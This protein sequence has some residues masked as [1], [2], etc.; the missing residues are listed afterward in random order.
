M[1]SPRT[2]KRRLA[3][4]WIISAADKLQSAREHYGLLIQ[5]TFSTY[6]N[7]HLWENDQSFIPKSVNESDADDVKTLK[8]DLFILWHA[9]TALR[10]SNNKLRLANE[11]IGLCHYLSQMKAV[12]ERARF[13]LEQLEAIVKIIKDK[14]FSIAS[15]KKNIYAILKSVKSYATDR[16]NAAITSPKKIN[17]AITYSL[18]APPAADKWWYAD[19]NASALSKK[20]K[21]N[22]EASILIDPVRKLMTGLELIFPELKFSETPFIR[23]E[24]VLGSRGGYLKA[25]NYDDPQSLENFR[26]QQTLQQSVIAIY[27]SAW[28][29]NRVVRN[30]STKSMVGAVAETPVTAFV[31]Q[32]LNDLWSIDFS[33]NIPYE[34]MER[35]TN[36]FKEF[37]KELK[38]NFLSF[39]ADKLASLQDYE[40]Q[41]H[42]RPGSITEL[43]HSAFEKV[44]DFYLAYGLHFENPFTPQRN[45]VSLQSLLDAPEEKRGETQ[46]TA[47]KKLFE[48]VEQDLAKYADRALPLDAKEREDFIIDLIERIEHLLDKKLVTDPIQKVNLEK[49]QE[50]L[51]AEL[52]SESIL[53]LHTYL[54]ESQ[55][56]NERA[57]ATKF[58]RAYT[59]SQS[60][61]VSSESSTAARWLAAA[62]TAVGA[63]TP[64]VVKT[65]VG[66]FFAPATAPTAIVGS[67]GHIHIRHDIRLTYN[68]PANHSLRDVYLVTQEPAKFIYIDANGNTKI[69]LHNED[70][71][72]QH[73]PFLLPFLD[74]GTEIVNELPAVIAIEEKSAADTHQAAAPTQPVESES[75][76]H[77]LTKPQLLQLNK[78]IT[79][80]NGP[81]EA[82]IL[83]PNLLE[84]LK[85]KQ[86]ECVAQLNVLERRNAELQDAIQQEEFNQQRDKYRSTIRLLAPRDLLT[87]IAAV[88]ASKDHPKLNLAYKNRLAALAADMDGRPRE[89]YL[90]I[91]HDKAVELITQ[92]HLLVSII[93]RLFNNPYSTEDDKLLC[94]ELMTELWLTDASMYVDNNV[95]EY[96]SEN[97]QQ[98]KLARHNCLSALLSQL[99]TVDLINML[100]R[101]NATTQLAA[102]FLILKNKTITKN[103]IFNEASNLT[104]AQSEE[105]G[106]LP[107]RQ[108]ILATLDHLYANT[109][110]PE[111][112]LLIG[113]FLANLAL[114]DITFA[115][116]VF[117]GELKSLA[118][119]VKKSC[120]E[121][122]P[123]FT[124][125][126]YEAWINSLNIQ[127]T[128]KLDDSI[129]RNQDIYRKMH[130]ALY[131]YASKENR[132]KTIGNPWELYKLQVDFMR[133]FITPNS[134]AEKEFILL[135]ANTAF[136]EGKKGHVIRQE[137]ASQF[138]KSNGASDASYYKYIAV[139]PENYSKFWN[140]QRINLKNEIA[141]QSR[142]IGEQQKL[143][144][145]SLISLQNKLKNARQKNSELN[146]ELTVLE[147]SF[148]K[149]ET[150]LK[151]LAEISA[152]LHATNKKMDRKCFEVHL[153]M[154][155]TLEQTASLSTI[156]FADIQ[157]LET[158]NPLT[159]QQ[160]RKATAKPPLENKSSGDGGSDTLSDSGDISE[161]QSNSTTFTLDE[162]APAPQPSE[163]QANNERI[164]AGNEAI[165]DQHAPQ[166]QMAAEISS[167]QSS[168]ASIKRKKIDKNRWR[169]SAANAIKST[170]ENLG[171]RVKQLFSDYTNQ[172]LWLDAALLVAQ[173]V[174]P[175]DPQDIKDL[176][177]SFLI[178][179]YAEDALRPNASMATIMLNLKNIVTA[180]TQMTSASKKVRSAIE[181]LISIINLSK[182]SKLTIENIHHRFLQTL[183]SVKTMVA[184]RINATLNPLLAKPTNT[185][186]TY[187]QPSSSQNQWWSKEY[188][189]SELNEF[190]KLNLEYSFLLDPVRKLMSGLEFIFPELQFSQAVFTN[191]GYYEIK[192][193]NHEETI[194]NFREQQTLKQSMMAIYNIMWSINRVSRSFTTHTFASATVDSGDF[195]K[196]AL[197]NLWLIDFSTNI[198]EEINRRFKEKFIVYLE[199]LRDGLLRFDPVNIARIRQYELNHHLKP[200]AI[201]E[202]L[203]LLFSRVEDFYLAYNI[204]FENPFSPRALARTNVAEE[205]KKLT[206]TEELSIIQ[207]LSDLDKLKKQYDSLAN[208]LNQFANGS[209]EEDK[210]TF[211]KQ[212]LLDLTSLSKSKH[213]NPEQLSITAAEII[214]ISKLNT[215]EV[216]RLRSEIKPESESDDDAL[217]QLITRL[218]NRPILETTF[219]PITGERVTFDLQVVF[220]LPDIYNSGRFKNIVMLVQEPARLLMF[221][222][223][224]KKHLIF[225]DENEIVTYAKFLA[226]FL[227]K[228]T[229]RLEET[230]ELITESLQSVNIPAPTSI[231]TDLTKE[232]LEKLDSSIQQK[233]QAAYVL[234]GVTGIIPYL[235]QKESECVEQIANLERAKIEV[236]DAK[237]V[238]SAQVDLA[239]EKILQIKKLLQPRD[240][241][242]M[243]NA[244][245]ASAR[246][247]KLNL[248][249]KSRIAALY[250][251][252]QDFQEEEKTTIIKN[253]HAIATEKSKSFLIPMIVELFQSATT[254]EDKFLCRELMTQLALSPDFVEKALLQTDIITYRSGDAR[255]NTDFVR[256]ATIRILEQ[257]NAADVVSMLT[258]SINPVITLDEE[259][260]PV[261]DAEKSLAV[262]MLTLKQQPVTQSNC[263]AEMISLRENLRFEDHSKSKIKYDLRYFSILEQL[264]QCYLSSDK[265]GALQQRIGL[266]MANLAHENKIFAGIVFDPRYQF[267]KTVQTT[268]LESSSTHTHL[269]YEAWVNSIA[270]HFPKRTEQ[271][272]KTYNQY[273]G[274]LHLNQNLFLQMHKTLYPQDNLTTIED[275]IINPWRFSVLLLDYKNRFLT[276][277]SEANQFITRLYLQVVFTQSDE[278]RNIR[279]MLAA[280]YYAHNGD[281][282]APYYKHI[283]N[284]AKTI[285][286]AYYNTFWD[287]QKFILLKE[288]F[289][290]MNIML[291]A[292]ENFPK[293]IS[294]DLLNPFD[295]ALRSIIADYQELKKAKDKIDLACNIAKRVFPLHL[296]DLTEAYQ[297]IQKH[298]ESAEQKTPAK[299]STKG[300]SGSL[301]QPA[302]RPSSS[303][304]A[305]PHATDIRSRALSF[306]STLQSS[307][308]T[309]PVRGPKPPTRKTPSGSASKGPRK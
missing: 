281:S 115:Q 246:H 165:A 2:P 113:V 49:S 218:N 241:L 86:Q 233:T 147:A 162:P 62:G 120:L 232:Q 239:H 299:S 98:D 257:C 130:D 60:I 253:A 132:I 4:S 251:E 175:N 153:M 18:P 94:R 214:L 89:Q 51:I 289:N 7:Q 172:Q 97:K 294:S 264:Q 155:N 109:A 213:D 304:E 205:E 112:R 91:A 144:M 118:D 142:Y 282:G 100:G 43:L 149:F 77:Q 278:C 275:Y 101:P 261:N 307:S 117:N 185:A 87:M 189:A 19:F 305:I 240:L 107:I 45:I 167:Q 138:Y 300:P 39:D 85:D 41:H 23:R 248:D 3:K 192:P 66:T 110:D 228:G 197:D 279:K 14:N 37:L 276:S 16:L 291:Q 288:I 247:P 166:Q 78:V 126:Y 306:F 30:F 249:I 52:S 190:E 182:D 181:G 6:T 119:I 174:K 263:E 99:N 277:G 24:G 168:T 230:D 64:D 81:D 187:Q 297:A 254:P 53:A 56:P 178:L 217:Q 204:H 258:E 106:K 199:A 36:R 256:N 265:D 61:H 157:R 216:T 150:A 303:S 25:N 209:Y 104:D 131:P 207:K 159:V 80:T 267:A 243:I 215:E 31:K 54:K 236:N 116:L 76:W 286:A 191:R 201:K 293:S 227:D 114:E 259:N 179:Q 266:F 210:Y 183:N 65:F 176:K 123:K 195:A 33:T 158:I 29:L 268:C 27:N 245:N 146:K 55:N 22:F 57:A 47:A 283:A 72:K 186:I 188:K 34:V 302:N 269:Y 156:I 102:F 202:L 301:G 292:K 50:L 160:S 68:L 26:Q 129:K 180:L 95:F 224:G 255:E 141:M 225:K 48:S 46:L 127:Q 67:H 75:I 38:K 193:W 237:T 235:R 108:L 73:A 287:E 252:T 285:D 139:N 170:R 42:L 40:I 63:Y 184:S 90:K 274:L 122:Q 145:N 169:E 295:Q 272:E 111:T 242:R 171:A 163:A 58:W 13:L 1:A 133:R 208:R 219:N 270:V 226:P 70:E 21:L 8:C 273:Q 17:T 105:S 203:Q 284:E 143:L 296:Q 234:Q 5:R 44:E 15:I 28:A 280:S 93:T 69:Y 309:Q 135:I 103:S 290:Q 220:A 238:N 154:R 125:L 124:H 134:K 148:K 12:S 196:R 244:I 211:I 140:E 20:Q 121:S 128:L 74:K 198:P 71:I 206:A 229:E 173:E 212:L 9:E 231:K 260:E 221:D 59:N 152:D 222:S 10:S 151:R 164:L 250:L 137:L 262:F 223:Q 161:T 298:L 200:G 35:L 194:R 32:A 83:N 308:T 177:Y 88:K 11:L 82:L 136:S 92:P 96:T 79:S 271:E 84:F